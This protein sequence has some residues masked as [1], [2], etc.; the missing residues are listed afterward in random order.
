MNT[1]RIALALLPFGLIVACST[2]SG[3]GTIVEDTKPTETAPEAGPAETTDSATP[4][5]PKKDSSVPEPPA[6]ECSSEATQTSCV[7]CCSNKHEDGAAVYFVA[8]IDCMCTVENCAKDCEATLCDAD[9][10]QNADAACQACVQAKSSKCSN[11]IKT[12]CTNDPDCTAFDA[13][14]GK[15]DCPGKSN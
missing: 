12:T 1:S 2:G 15:S 11:I 6:G 14:V 10:P 13:C 9:N 4:P 5:P 3:G 7:T 8:L